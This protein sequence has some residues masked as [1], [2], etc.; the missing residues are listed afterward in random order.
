LGLNE[1]E[2]PSKKKEKLGEEI[3]G[4]KEVEMT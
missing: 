3:E 4:V 1:E 2:W